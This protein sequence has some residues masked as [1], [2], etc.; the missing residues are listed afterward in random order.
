MQWNILKVNNLWNK[1]EIILGTQYLQ[2]K[3]TQYLLN[4]FLSGRG[5]LLAFK[6]REI[7]LFIKTPILFFSK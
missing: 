2:F 7:L 6:Y 5:G 1:R 3:G 4:T